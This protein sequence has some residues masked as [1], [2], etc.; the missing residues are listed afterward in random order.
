MTRPKL[1]SSYFP[2]KNRQG[3][4]DVLG[5]VNLFYIFS[6]AEQNSE[7][8]RVFSS[9]R[10]TIRGNVGRPS[11]CYRWPSKGYTLFKSMSS[12]SVCAS[13]GSK[14]P[15]AAVWIV[16]G[17]SALC[18]TSVISPRS[19]SQACLLAEHATDGDLEH[20]IFC[21]PVFDVQSSLHMHLQVGETSS[22]PTP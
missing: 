5:Q 17:H 7:K 18:P 22:S 10:P 16:E 12:P 2:I 13:G 21:K 4:K 14:R 6:L 19:R 1:Y 8:H 3:H 9:Y 15:S 11:T 20:I